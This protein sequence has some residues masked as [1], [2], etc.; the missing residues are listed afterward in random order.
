MEKDNRQQNSKKETKET[1][2]ETDKMLNTFKCLILEK[3][4]YM[5]KKAYNEYKKETTDKGFDLWI[6]EK[7]SKYEN[8]EMYEILKSD[9]EEAIDYLNEIYEDLGTGT[10]DELLEEIKEDDEKLYGEL[11]YWLCSYIV[12]V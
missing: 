11:L 8:E 10:T 2:E 6:C 1:K 7:R 3:M 9:R 12:N 5:L 4:F